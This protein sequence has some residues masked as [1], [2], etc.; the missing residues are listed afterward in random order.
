[1]HPRHERLVNYFFAGLVLVG[2][3]VTLTPSTH[4]QSYRWWRDVKVQRELA[5]T[6]DQVKRLETVFVSTLAERRKLRRELDR[7]EEHVGQIIARADLNMSRASAWIEQL[8][9]ARAKRNVARTLML[10]KMHRILTPKQRQG[11][12]QMGNVARSKEGFSR[13]VMQAQ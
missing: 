6:A 7:L 4:A 3:I 2:A 13:T 5:L 1:V 11:L 10:F 8:E 12:L 9:S